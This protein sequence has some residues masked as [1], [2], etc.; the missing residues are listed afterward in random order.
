[1]AIALRRPYID[2]L[3]GNL[4]VEYLS[5]EKVAKRYEFLRSLLGCQAT[6]LVAMPSGLERLCE[7]TSD[8]WGMAATEI[9]EKLTL[10]PYYVASSSPRVSMNVL[11]AMTRS[12]GRIRNRC[13]LGFGRYTNL[14]T[15]RY[16][17]QCI[18]E[19]RDSWRHPYFRRVHQ[20][21]GVAVCPKHESLLTCS[22]LRASTLHVDGA[23]AFPTAFE[24]GRQIEFGHTR[25][26]EIETIVRVAKKSEEILT[27]AAPSS[28]FDLR[29]HYKRCLEGTGYTYRG[30]NCR[31]DELSTDIVEYF[32]EPFL[33]WVGLFRTGQ[34]ARDWLVPLLCLGQAVAPTV[35]H[36]L[37]QQFIASGVRNRR[38]PMENVVVQCPCDAPEHEAG[39]FKGNLV[40]QGETGGTAKCVCGSSFRFH[41]D[42]HASVVDQIWRYAHCYHG[43]ATNLTGKGLSVQEIALELRVSVMTAR[44]LC[45]GSSPTWSQQKHVRTSFD[46][47]RGR[48]AWLEAIERFGSVASA[49]RMAR[50]TYRALLR[51]DREW[52]AEHRT[53]ATRS[54]VQ[55]VDWARR[56]SAYVGVLRAAA[57]AISCEIP[58]RWVSAISI[59]MVSRVP[60][61]TRN[62]LVK[63]PKCRELLKEVVE[64]RQQF[65]ERKELAEIRVVNTDDKAAPDLSLVD[66]ERCDGNCAFSA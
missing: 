48:Q 17:R 47:E 1:M 8:Y 58:P 46:V 19:D 57:D 30:G 56:D 18:R 50:P 31:L 41:L 61:G 3:L 39:V 52:L 65:R 32:G 45:R 24:G 64:T 62:Q 23:S 33:Y 40:W 7:Q 5:E 26:I 16:C 29:L 9:A 27:H 51:H 38:R 44:R 11:A 59:L 60:R 14:E 10:M 49:R 6:S 54:I 13:G 34:E 25:P 21:P 4:I 37:L 22:E 43:M 20:L 36:V 12:S 28:Y 63:L 42:G 35:S 2:E 66:E 15:L 55:R 53:N